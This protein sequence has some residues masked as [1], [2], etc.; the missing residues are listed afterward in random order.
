MVLQHLKHCILITASDAGTSPNA[1]L[2]EQVNFL[3]E[4]HVSTILLPFLFGA[5]LHGL[6]KNIDDLRPIAVGCTY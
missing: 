5:Q 3:A 2:I 6:R 4:A 1:H